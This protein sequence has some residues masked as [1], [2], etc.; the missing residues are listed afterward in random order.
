MDSTTR[1]KE[2]IVST[3]NDKATTHGSVRKRRDNAIGVGLLGLALVALAVM[4]PSAAGARSGAQ[5]RAE[6]VAAVATATTSDFRV[7]VVAERLGGGATPTAEVTAAVAQRV[8]RSW[9]ERRELRLA[10]T[11]FWRTVTGPRAVCRVEIATAS[12][13]TGGRPYVSIRLLQSPSLGCG[14]THRL[15]LPDR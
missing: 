14:P 1:R 10:E 6:R 15:A 2:R 4:L 5:T 8:G 9:R 12:T 7:A 11:Y 3:V 13:P